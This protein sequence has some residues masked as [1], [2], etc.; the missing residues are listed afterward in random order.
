MERMVAQCNR[1]LIQRFSERLDRWRDVES[2]PEDQRYNAALD[3]VKEY[4]TLLEDEVSK[5]KRQH[6]ENYEARQR[7]LWKRRLQPST[8]IS[9]DEPE[10]L[11]GNESE[12]HALEELQRCEQEH[13]IWCLFEELIPIRYPATT[14]PGTQETVLPGTV[15]GNSRFAADGDDF[16]QFIQKDGEA[17]ER[18]VVM[19]WLEE[20]SGRSGSPEIIEDELEKR[21]KR[22]K[23]L[24]SSGWIN[25]RE[26]IK[27][28][29]RLRSWDTS[30]DTLPHLPDSQGNAI[31][32]Q[33]DPDAVTR[34]Q[35]AL[36][37][38]DQ[39]FNNAFWLIC[40]EY[41]RRG[42]P[43]DKLLE[44]CELCNET[45]TAVTLGMFTEVNEGAES[46]SNAV[47]RYRWRKTCLAAASQRGLH[48]SEAAV[49]GLLGG[50]LRSVEGRCADWKDLCHA[51]L[52]AD[53]IGRYR[54]HIKE[55]FNAR[56][57]PD[58]LHNFG[59]RQPLDLGLNLD[60]TIS[61]V[62][63]HHLIRSRASTY[64]SSSVIQ[65]ALISDTL[66]RLLMEQGAG[67]AYEAVERNDYIHPGS[68]VPPN[69]SDLFSNIQKVQKLT[70]DP[71]ALRILTHI[72][73]VFR[74]LG[75][76]YAHGQIHDLWSEAAEN[77]CAWYVQLLYS[78]Q[79]YHLIPVYAC[80]VH[81]DL[82]AHVTAKTMTAIQDDQQ[83]AHFL[84]SMEECHMDVFG[85]LDLQM[86]YAFGWF[87]N[88]EELDEDVAYLQLLEDAEGPMWPGKRIQSS[89]TLEL[90]DR[91]EILLSCGEWFT[92]AHG[93][94]FNTFNSLLQIME[95]FLCELILAIYIF[96]ILLT[97]TNSDYGRV[98]T[99]VELV[100]RA[101]P[102]NV[103][104]RKALD[105]LGVQVDVF[106]EILDPS[107][108]LDRSTAQQIKILHRQALMYEHCT[109]LVE[110]IEA[111]WE[112]R[113]VEDRLLKFVLCHLTT[114]YSTLI[115]S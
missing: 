95:H 100:R 52:N 115:P 67:L 57:P 20:C 109:L 6:G 51:H 82:G 97:G 79:D 14:S 13:Q 85:I 93:E 35:L 88:N 81:P 3:L 96:S 41:L 60:Q 111:M 105:C 25:T 40:F 47:A 32:Q 75:V 54:S 53:I 34:L 69:Q 44:W 108:Q 28:I 42:L 107:P 33:L 43:M 72:F 4:R 92:L 17:R 99:A 15:H 30:T 76:R 56:L 87:T 58:Q 112:W 31:V 37:P 21:S 61:S 5:L 78:T 83:R 59:D 62:K 74:L 7:R 103:S 50:D 16:T 9:D 19:K 10:Q 27:S 46:G 114:S 91:E 64:T 29:K 49:F 80:N 71:E 66:P 65:M 90:T 89:E 8:S 39:D 48:A 86:Q 23:D 18:L 84:R 70:G 68:M 106:E 24:W 98:Q 1:G 2:L 12:Q 36:D 73:I 26:K 55:R 113:L 45:A 94:W 77:V 110:A 22:G 38:Q 101:S 11:V 104:T 63:E 102:K